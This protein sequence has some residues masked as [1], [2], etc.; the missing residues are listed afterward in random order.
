[1]EK[2]YIARKIS[3]CKKLISTAISPEQE[4]IYQGY[5]KFWTKVKNTTQ[6]AEPAESDPAVEQFV[7][8]YPNKKAYYKRNGVIHQTKAF[9]EFLKNKDVE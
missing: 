1:M 3:N 5:M 7:A 8:E 6:Q 2:E 9:Q 4:K